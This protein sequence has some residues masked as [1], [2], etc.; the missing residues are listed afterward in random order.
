MLKLRGQIKDALETAGIEK[1]VLMP[2][3]LNELSSGVEY[4]YILAFD[5]VAVVTGRGKRDRAKVIFDSLDKSPTDHFKAIFV[6][7]Y[8]KLNPAKLKRYVIACSDVQE[9]QK[10]EVLLHKKIGGNTT[11]VDFFKERFF[12]NS[13]I[14]LGS[15]GC[16][17]V[18]VV[19]AM[20]F[21][22]SYSGLT[23]LK[24]WRKKHLISDDIWHEIEKRLGSHLI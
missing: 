24:K 6:R 20:A 14:P 7:A 12:P 4:V 9:S 21:N 11:K 18:D 3:A 23:D 15:D 13:E 16:H 10:I 2:K 19:I 5:N 17:V 22:S 1:N 8:N